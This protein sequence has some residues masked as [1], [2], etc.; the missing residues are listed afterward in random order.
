MFDGTTTAPVQMDVSMTRVASRGGQ[1]PAAAVRRR[2][3]A[4]VRRP[5][6]SMSVLLIAVLEHTREPWRMLAEAR[7]VLKPGGRAIMVVPNDVTM[8]AGRLLLAQVSDPLSGSPDVHD[9]AED[10]PLAARR[11]PDPRSVHAAVPARCRSP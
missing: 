5:S 4:A 11:L 9:A 7:R 10:A 2:L 3:S 1:V 8:S 6:R